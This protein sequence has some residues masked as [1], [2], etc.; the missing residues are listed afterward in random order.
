MIRALIFDLDDTLYPEHE[1]VASGYRAV[2]KHLSATSG[3]P[4]EDIERTMMALW[5]REGRR[6]VLPA[7]LNHCRCESVRVEE[8][9]RV[10]RQHKPNIR[11]FP[12]YYDLLREFRSAYRL[13]IIT[14]GVSP[15]Q[16]AKC[17]ALG[18]EEIVDSIICTWEYGKEKE[19][20]NPY[21]FCLQM[22]CLQVQPDEAL[23]IGDNWEKDCLGARG[24]G[25]RCVQV[26]SPLLRRGGGRE[27]EA[28]FAVDSLFQLPEVLR[29]LEDRN[30]AA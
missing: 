22:A 7:A 24:V 23:F 29:K 10:Y 1:F 9:V 28:D 17:A 21:S 15:V 27:E 18:L 20:P 5:T 19:K 2:A 30:E 4:E 25:M 12:G 6:N 14:D 3:M 8:L 26:Q 16:R 11:L 13:G